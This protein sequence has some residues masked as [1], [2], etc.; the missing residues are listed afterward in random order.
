M[1][2]WLTFVLTLALSVLTCGIG[3]AQQPATP[4]PDETALGELVIPIGTT[5]QIPLPKIAV[6]PSLSPDYEDVI[7]RSVVRR[8]I[9]LTGLFEVIPDSKAPPG[10]YGFD[11]P[12]DVDAWRKVGAE[13]IVKVSAR[14]HPSGKIEVLGVAYFI[15]DSKDP[16]YQKK[17][18]VNKD[19]VRVTAHRITDA[20]LFALTGRA[21]GFAS[22]FVFSSRWGKNRRI[23]SMDADGHALTPHTDPAATA[24]SPAWGP[25]A[26]IFY[27]VSVNYAPFKLMRL[28]ADGHKPVAIPF[29]T[30]VYSMAFNKDHTK[31][32]IAVA[33]AA[34]SSIYVGNPDGSGMQ[35]VSTTELAT[36][37]VFSPSGKL[38]W[39]GGGAK[40]GSQRVYLEG[41][42]ISPPAFTAAAPAFCN[43][44]DGIKI[45]YAVGVAG[46]RQ[47]LVMSSENGQG[48]QR[49]TQGQ[50]SNSYPACSSDGR[51]LA[52]FSTRNK[53]P[54]IYLM[55]LKRWTTLKLSNQEG[56]SLR[57][58][59]LPPPPPAGAP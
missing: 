9:E 27:A 23:F 52:F 10:L 57:W 29:K 38:A 54:G 15:K 24:L 4:P 22:H 59:P 6:L 37:P 18:V 3:A 20:M 33:E 31:L 17:L 46:N 51:L 14:K 1:M 8:D 50:G 25:N 49:L 53:S 5:G 11:D 13:D 21:G 40:K 16:V 19:D 39:L 48:I 42:A 32:A 2:R 12:I 7:V 41:K 44:E 28:G 55:S 56:E 45:V 26:Q 35:K 58:D 36:H 43:T 47:D 30:S 34:K